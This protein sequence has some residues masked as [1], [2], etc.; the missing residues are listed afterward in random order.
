MGGRHATT[1]PCRLNQ[2][3]QSRRF[4]ILI[5]DLKKTV[6]CEV[7]RA[8][9]HCFLWAL[10][11]AEEERSALT[12]PKAS[13]QPSSRWPLRVLTPLRTK[14]QSSHRA[15][16]LFWSFLV[17]F[18]SLASVSPGW[19]SLAA[20]HLFIGVRRD[21]NLLS[22]QLNLPPHKVWEGKW[23]IVNCNPQR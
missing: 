19:S 10:H 21:G 18:V 2:D 1:T 14:L 7:A 12:P 11:R 3:A 8:F 20:A 5:H 22:L 17:D 13:L 6:R 16:A 9:G 4:Q 15:V 23:A